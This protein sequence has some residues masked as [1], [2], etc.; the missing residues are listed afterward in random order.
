MN[1]DNEEE[2][3]DREFTEKEI[4]KVSVYVNKNSGTLIKYMRGDFETLK[5]LFPFG[6][7]RKI[8]IHKKPNNKY[9]VVTADETK[10]YTDF[11]SAIKFVEEET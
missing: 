3:N 10:V 7:D 5:M 9:N 2:E 8:L 6:I 1:K 4:E 11:E